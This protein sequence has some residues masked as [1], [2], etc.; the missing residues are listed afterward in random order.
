MNDEIQL[1]WDV[2][3]DCNKQ[4]CFFRACMITRKYA[5]RMNI[6]KQV[7]VNRSFISTKLQRNHR[8]SDVIRES[9]GLSITIECYLWWKWCDSWWWRTSD[10][11]HNK[12]SSTILSWN[13]GPRC[14]SIIYMQIEMNVILDLLL[15]LKNYR[16]LC[17]L[18]CYDLR[19][20]RAIEKY[21]KWK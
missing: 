11:L 17:H 16:N 8:H 4:S 15:T 1:M 5:E 19:L 6:C 21:A 3:K 2:N 9:F 18:G 20:W 14:D 13:N 7:C 10:S 12:K